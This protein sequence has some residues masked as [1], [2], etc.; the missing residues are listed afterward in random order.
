MPN[1]L[2]GKNDIERLDSIWRDM[3]AANG[4]TRE[5]AYRIEK[6]ILRL[7]SIVDKIFVKTV[8]AHDILLEC[9]QMTEQFKLELNK[10]PDK[11]LQILTQIE[12]QVDDL[13]KKTHAFRIKAG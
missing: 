13:V 11:T 12:V 7:D 9:E 2:K 10:Q 3:I 8:K 6:L 4:L 1:A 5:L